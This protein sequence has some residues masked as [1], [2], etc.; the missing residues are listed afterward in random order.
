MN[1]PLM[2]RRKQNRCRSAPAF[3]FEYITEDFMK[4]VLATLLGLILI[5]ST[6]FAQDGGRDRGG[7]RGPGGGEQDR[8]GDR[9]P[10]RGG[11]RGGDRTPDRGGTPDRSAPKA[12]QDY[13]GA[14]G[15]GNFCTNCAFENRA[16]VPQ[17]G[18]KKTP[19]RY[20]VNSDQD[21]VDARCQELGWDYGQ[22]IEWFSYQE[23]CK[24]GNA[25]TRMWDRRA[26]D[27]SFG[28]CRDGN[29]KLARCFRK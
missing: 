8:G 28:S 19:D 6:G 13:S 4:T 16:D 27:W 17:T 23:W 7:S 9:G 21:S 2:C 11:D 18:K 20:L 1:I 26:R 10:D 3:E 22:A 25:K 12:S 15:P 14:I 5:S 29:V 24:Y